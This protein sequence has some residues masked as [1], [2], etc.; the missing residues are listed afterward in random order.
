MLEPKLN[1]DDVSMIHNWFKVKM[2]ALC[3]EFNA[4]YLYPK[5]RFYPQAA[6]IQLSALKELID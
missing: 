3:H 4:K 2:I 6:Y 5:S 1:Q